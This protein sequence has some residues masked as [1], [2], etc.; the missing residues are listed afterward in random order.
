MAEEVVVDRRVPPTRIR[1]GSL[2]LGWVSRKKK[3]VKR[4]FVASL[5]FVVIRW[6]PLGERDG[7]GA[8]T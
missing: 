2:F 5:G 4:N 6:Y 3:E 7:H 8:S 1:R